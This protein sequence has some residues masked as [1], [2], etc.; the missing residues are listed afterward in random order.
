MTACPICCG[1]TEPLLRRE[2]VPVHQH[3][4]Y[5]TREAARNCVRGT[6][7]MYC[8]QSCGFIF[9]TAF[10]PS[11]M[12]YGSDYDNS[13]NHGGDFSLYLDG[14]I[15]DL[16]ERGVEHSRVVEVGCGNGD[17][18]RKLVHAGN[19]TGVGYDS[20]Y[21]GPAEEQDLWFV[22]SDYEPH[23]L[24]D[25]IISR[26]VLEHVQDPVTFIETMADGLYDNGRMFIETPDVTPILANGVSWDFFYEHCSMFS[27]LAL[28]RACETAGLEV[29][30]IERVFSGQYLMGVAGKFASTHMNNFVNVA[31][32][33]VDFSFKAHARDVKIWAALLE[34]CQRRP[35]ALLGAGAKGATFAGLFDPDT[36][37][38]DCIVDTN[39]A[40]QGKYLPGTGHQI[41]GLDA[42]KERGIRTL[43]LMNPNYRPAMS[44]AVRDLDCTLEDVP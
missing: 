39:P 41:I 7:D 10:D 30:S 20:A 24:A 28:D 29:S 8:C 4:L 37:Y 14:V 44:E 3:K 33:S 9:N 6:L 16:I 35:I 21:R 40:K 17:F 38:L 27:P 34:W 42:I 18:L 19:N 1:A 5:T 26:H 15:A 11:L 36:T 25:A 32:L 31:A 2:H 13:Q 22:K 12:D 43:I 23:E